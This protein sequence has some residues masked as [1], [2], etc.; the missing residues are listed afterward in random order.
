MNLRLP[1]R[2]VLLDKAI[3][4]I[5]SVGVELYPG[6]NV[7]EVAKPYAR[8]LM[9]ERFQPQRVAAR[10]RKEAWRLA[11][12]A[13]EVPY[14]LHDILE[15]LRDGEIEVGFVHKGLDEFMVRMNVAFNRLVVA[16][17]VTGGLIGSSLI[18]IFAKSGPM[19]LGINVLSLVGFILSGGL[20]IWLLW[21]V[22][23][24]G[25]L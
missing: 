2:F 1:S 7:F 12:M 19:V 5:G 9:I 17:V 21:G 23:R 18:G 20:G 11:S 24:S 10:G 6:F 15:E 13:A 8:S 4:T 3:A 14:Q 22:I 16:L 25:R